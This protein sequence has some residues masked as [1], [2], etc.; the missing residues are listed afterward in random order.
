MTLTR[1]VSE[2]RRCYFLG[3]I[4]LLAKQGDS[5]QINDGQQRLVTI[6][7]ICACLCRLFSEASDSLREARALRLLFDLDE[8]STEQFCNV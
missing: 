6:S 3:A 7:L 8:N 1:R 4:M 5:W 2:N